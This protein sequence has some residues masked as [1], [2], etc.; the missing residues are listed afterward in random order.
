MWLCSC[1]DVFVS[2]LWCGCAIVFAV[3]WLCYCF[4]G[5]V[6]VFSSFCCEDC[7]HQ[8]KQAREMARLRTQKKKMEG[9]AH[10]VTNKTNKMGDR[11]ND[12]I[13]KT[14]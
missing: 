11:W 8:G 6:A 4:C 1:G 3:V 7:R 14:N 5:V 10:L 13:Q 9:K 12:K 2:L